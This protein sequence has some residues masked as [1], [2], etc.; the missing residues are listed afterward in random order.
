MKTNYNQKTYRQLLIIALVLA[1]LYG[2]AQAVST[3][4]FFYT[5]AV[6]NFTIPFCT[7]ALTIEVRGA[8]GGSLTTN[9]TH[10]GGLGAIMRGEFTPTPG[11]VLNVI[12][13]QRGKPDASSAGGGGGSGVNQGTV[14]LIVAGGGGGADFQQQSYAGLNANISIN[15]NP[16]QNSGGA[17]GTAGSDGGDW[18]YSSV[19][20]ARGGRGWNTSN[21][22]G[23][24]GQN[25]QS[26]NTTTTTGTYG[27]G[28]GG[29]SVGSGY[30]N[31]GGGGG[32]YSGGGAGNIN[33]SGG[34]GGSYNTG[35]NQLNTAGINSGNGLVIINY[36]QDATVAAV[37]STN[38][39]CNGSSITFTASGVTTYTWS[40]G[41]TSPIVT[42]APSTS[43][44]YVVAG[45]NTNGCVSSKTF[46][47]IVNNAVPSLTVT[48][49]T[50][51]CIGKTT[52][53]TASGALS[54]SWSN[55]APNGGTF[56]PTATTIYT[57]TG[58]NGCGSSSVA[59]TVT[60][61]PIPV[62]ASTQPTLICA[63]KPAVLSA[64]GAATGFSWQ[65]NA[66]TGQTITVSPSV[67]TVYTVT[68]TDG[69]CF[70]TAMVTLSVNP[71]PTVL[72]VASQTNICPNDAVTLTANGNGTYSWSPGGSTANSVTFAPT[73]SAL[74]TVD[75]T[76]SFGCTTRT[77]QVVVIIQAPTL[78]VSATQTMICNGDAVTLTAS[79][80]GTGYSW[81]TSQTT[82]VI[83]VSPVA[84]TIY[85]VTATN[86]TCSTIGT[87]PI[88]VFTPSLT[89]TGNSS[90]C[91]GGTA[92][93]TGNGMDSYD[94]D[95]IGTFNPI[96]VIPTAQTV[97]SLNATITLTNNLT[98]NASKT[99]TVS[100]YAA[101]SISIAANR[102]IMCT[103][104]TLTLTAGGATSYMWST[105]STSPSITFSSTAGG[106]FTRSVV[107]T[108]VNGCT[109]SNVI[110][111][112]VN[113]CTGIAEMTPNNFMIYPNPSNGEFT[114]T[115]ELPVKAAL[116]SET[117][118]LIR[119]LDLNEAN[120]NSISIRSLPSGVYL[121]SSDDKRLNQKIVIMQ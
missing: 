86:G 52:T 79:G 115:S 96:T 60:A 102:T 5:G 35:T 32:G 14:P 22:N 25:G 100:L 88:T 4:S 50:S 17:A 16:G 27:L 31:C 54:Y 12:V 114:I 66:P 91:P 67:T 46:A 103:K 81:S 108:D 74:Y 90:V 69:T 10:L 36:T 87:I 8:Q 109:G 1:G 64:V 110:S 118:Q 6:Q 26:A 85:T 13:G 18:I 56:A 106:T 30:C 73:A 113:A 45:T 78:N 40:H 42:V 15:G 63:N 21:P 41:P 121:I 119:L 93:L 33:N 104:E 61:T 2:K 62:A 7:N 58:Y 92:T 75:V 43:T 57:L 65:P 83:S 116:F 3:Q 95:G 49:T 19:N 53:L 47:V 97:Y 99:F 70:G 84:S 39:I 68:A 59:I 117:G 112:K 98:C 29:G 71:N 11:V 89:I 28:G 120:G 51:V 48:G 24:V 23:M 82:N 77:T 55:G 94:W 111:I 37:S 76:N 44:T 38:T 107:G 34:G 80:N 101:P 20:I 9:G 72:V 105:T